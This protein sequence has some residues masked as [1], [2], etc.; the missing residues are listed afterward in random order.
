MFFGVQMMLKG[1]KDQLATNRGP[2]YLFARLIAQFCGEFLFGILGCI[3]FFPRNVH[4]SELLHVRSLS[5]FLSDGQ[6]WALWSQ[7]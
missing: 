3:V 6:T 1:N 7:D 2:T 4:G 5:P